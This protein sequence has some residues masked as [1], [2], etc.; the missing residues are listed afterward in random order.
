MVESGVMLMFI[1][2]CYKDQNMCSKAVHNYIY[3]LESAPDCCK[4]KKICDKP[5][6]AYPYTIHLFLINLSLKKCVMKLT[7]LI[8]LYL[9]LSLINI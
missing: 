7:V 6:I 3:S 1:P 8:H 9:I 4:T 5:V 2:E